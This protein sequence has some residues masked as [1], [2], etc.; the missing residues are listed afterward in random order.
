MHE[1]FKPAGTPAHPAG[2]PPAPAGQDERTWGMLAHL[3]AFLGL[4]IPVVGNVLAPW[5]IWQ[6]RRDRSPFV[7]EQ[8]KEALNF[9]I[10][11]SL[12]LLVCWVL[13]YAFIGVLFCLIVL[14][15]GWLA[16]TLVAGIKAG[17][18]VHYRYPVSL[19]LVR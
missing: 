8:A 14:F 18:G 7:A 12:A 15:I 9:N 6:A 1:P 11:V 19:R 16:L 10:C 2:T 17:E 5:I 4:V 3:S 13:K